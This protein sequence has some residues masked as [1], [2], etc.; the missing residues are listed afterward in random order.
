MHRSVGKLVRVVS[1]SS[2]VNDDGPGLGQPVGQPLVGLYLVGWG[3]SALLVGLSGAVNPMGYAS[4]TYCALGPGP[5][6]IPVLVPVSALFV[7]IF[8]RALMVS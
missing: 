3:V 4:T 2:D 1:D 5:G 8:T 6:F 7:F